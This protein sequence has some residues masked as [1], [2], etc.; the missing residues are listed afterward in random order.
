MQRTVNTSMD[1][2]VEK[3]NRVFSRS[4]SSEYL[5]FST[6]RESIT[7]LRRAVKVSSP[8]VPSANRDS[9]VNKRNKKNI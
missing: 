1:K 9:R 6:Y 5:S 4:Y 7:T 8:H 3:N 2:N